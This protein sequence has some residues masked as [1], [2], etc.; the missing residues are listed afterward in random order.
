M[1]VVREGIP[2]SCLY[3]PRYAK[4]WTPRGVR[5]ARWK[6]VWVEGYVG[7]YR[8]LTSAHF[9]KDHKTYHQTQ[10]P[11]YCQASRKLK[12]GI[13]TCTLLRFNGV[14][15]LPPYVFLLMLL[16]NNNNCFISGS[17]KILISE[18]NYRFRKY[19]LLD[20]S[21]TYTISYTKK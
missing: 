14:V 21:R 7:R 8:N 12:F 5:L 19:L 4:Q 6:M 16:F 15:L 13:L 18:A 10:I 9:D 1:S 17:C 3:A 11:Y 2:T 20:S